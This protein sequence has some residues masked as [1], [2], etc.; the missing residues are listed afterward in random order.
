MLFGLCFTKT[1]SEQPSH[2]QFFIF[3]SIKVTGRIISQ[4]WVHWAIGTERLSCNYTAIAAYFSAVGGIHR[5]YGLWQY[6]F[7]LCIEV[8]CC[9]VIWVAKLFLSFNDYSACHKRHKSCQS[10]FYSTMKAVT[11]NITEKYLRATIIKYVVFPL[12]SAAKG[13]DKW[14]LS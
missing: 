8:I 6:S 13:F 5:C 12:F 11:P 2:I 14:T 10:S 4:F 7:S 9:W 1:C 3:N